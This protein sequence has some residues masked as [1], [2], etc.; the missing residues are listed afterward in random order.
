MDGEGERRMTNS[1]ATFLDGL[2]GNKRRKKHNWPSPRELVQR[3]RRHNVQRALSFSVFLSSQCKDSAVS[4]AT[5]QR[6]VINNKPTL[7]MRQW[8]SWELSYLQGLLSPFSLLLVPCATCWRARTTESKTTSRLSPS[9]LT[10][11]NL[12]QDAR[13]PMGS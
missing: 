12:S 4:S 9:L 11:S 10:R 8:Q 1:W 2:K 3:S 7:S 5:P 6:N 13:R